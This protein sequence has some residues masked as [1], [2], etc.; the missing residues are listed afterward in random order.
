[1]KTIVFTGDSHTWGEGAAIDNPPDYF[2]DGSPA[3]AGELRRMRSEYP[4]FVNLL[5]DYFSGQYRVI[6]SGIGSCPALRYL[7]EYWKDYVEKYSPDI[8]VIQPHTINDW[9][10][11]EGVDIYQEHLMKYVQKA[12]KTAP[13]VLLT[14]VSPILG[15]QKVSNNP[16]DCYEDY[17]DQIYKVGKDLDIP[18]ADVFPLLQDPKYFSDKWHVNV[19]GHQIYAN[20]IMEK[21]KTML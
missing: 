2:G 13:K 18:I 1:M 3:V 15:E 14:T 5:T 10:T 17:I 4:S 11:G 12:K 7:E 21:L 16:E 6:N 19:E 8:I 9:L 20:I